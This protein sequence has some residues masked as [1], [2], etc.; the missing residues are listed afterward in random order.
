MK[1]I[2]AVLIC[3]IIIFILVKLLMDYHSTMI[4]KEI[5][6]VEVLNGTNQNG[7]AKEISQYLKDNQLD[8]I[9][10]SNAK[11]DTI[12]E[13]IVIDRLKKNC[14]YGKYVAKKLNCNNIMS[15]IDS[16]LYIDVTIIIG[17]DYKKYLKEKTNGTE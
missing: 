12:S 15:D 6:R 9:I 13:T 8:V 17:N 11:F 2:I 14:A 5:L 7:L 4:D 3:I 16:S 10:I 1:K